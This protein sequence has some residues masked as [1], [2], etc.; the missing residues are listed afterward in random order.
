[1]GPAPGM[2][3]H[4]GPRSFLTEEEKRNKPKISWSL[5]KRILRYL[6]PYSFQFLL[7]FLALAIS[8]FLGLMPSIVTGKIVDQIVSDNR[9][10]QRLIELLVLA[11]GILAASQIISVLEQYI[12]SWI[13]QMII[14]DMRNQMY[15]HLQHMSHEFFTKEKQGDII[16]RMNS[17]INGVS[18]VISGT[19]TS[20]VSNILTIASSV[21]YLFYTNWCLALVGIA[22]I[23][24]LILPT[25]LVGKKRWTLLTKSQEKNDMLNQHIDETLSVSGSMLVKLFTREEKEYDKFKNINKDVTDITVKEQRTGSWFHVF[26]GLFMQL[27]PLLIYFAGGYIIMKTSSDL[28]VGDITVVVSLVNRLNMPVR[29]ILNI[30]VDFTRSLA[31]FS[32]IFEY[33]DKKSSIVTPA[34]PKSVDFKNSCIEFKD[35]HFA[36]DRGPK[37]LKGVDFLIPKGKMYA[38]VGPSGAGK[39][40]VVSLIPRL[41]DALDGE[42]RISGVNVKDIDLTELRSN[43]GMVSQDTYLFNGTIMENLLYAKDNATKD[44]IEA[45]C[46]IANIHNFIVSLPYGYHTQVGNRGLK[47]SGGEKQR[48]SIARVVLKDPEI[49]IL[50]E[51]TSSLD[52]ISESLIQDS[53]DKLMIGRTSLIIAHRLTT[54]LAA[55]RIMVLSKGKI[56]ENGT[57]NQLMKDSVI[58]REL[59]ETQFRKVLDIENK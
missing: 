40:T 29:N 18:S 50:D 3:G 33:F 7:V 13:S 37:I 56:I 4:R 10:M 8:A 17:D 22:I 31:L 35:V 55:D 30:Q 39:S 19:L 49:L 32:R 45:A 5:I 24:I 28:T 51:A 15:N 52:S 58:Y 14:K 54:V 11:F 36:Y 16:T 46:K 9:S 43:I 25:R 38:I 21:F 53:L 59:F 57:H 47:L 48:I 20:I 34:N 1:M 2:G 26:M 44:E 41:Y 6:K 27:T 12:N 23:P 42:V